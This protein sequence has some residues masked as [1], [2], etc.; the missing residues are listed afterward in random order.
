MQCFFKP[1]SRRFFPNKSYFNCYLQS[2]ANP[3]IYSCSGNFAT[4]LQSGQV[5]R[6]LFNFLLMKRGICPTTSSCL[7]WSI[8]TIA[9]ACSLYSFLGSLLQN[10]ELSLIRG[11]HTDVYSWYTREN[12]LVVCEESFSKVIGNSISRFSAKIFTN[13]IFSCASSIAIPNLSI[14]VAHSKC[15][16]NVHLFSKCNVMSS[17][18]VNFWFDSSKFWLVIWKRSKYKSYRYQKPIL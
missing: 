10:K 17:S 16:R 4:G 8:A 6:N 12:L 9:T 18:N 13:N 5:P 2:Y 1:S 15:L 7:K 14:L 3:S 11:I